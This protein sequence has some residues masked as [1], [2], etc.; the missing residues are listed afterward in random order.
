M[1]LAKISGRELFRGVRAF[2]EVPGFD[3][4][5][6]LLVKSPKTLGLSKVADDASKKCHK[7]TDS[8]VI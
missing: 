5:V 1:A 4:S 8:N 2:F 3:F 7:S 6:N